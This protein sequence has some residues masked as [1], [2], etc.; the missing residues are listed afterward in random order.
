MHV[1]GGNS[2]YCRSLVARLLLEVGEHLHTLQVSL[3]SFATEYSSLY[4]CK[5]TFGF[6]AFTL[7]A[8]NNA[9][10]DYL[11]WFSILRLAHDGTLLACSLA[12]WSLQSNKRSV[13]SLALFAF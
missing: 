13:M 12:H 2:K 4:I 10:A 11:L 7:A 1:L 3:Q 9:R 8:F 5:S 6:A